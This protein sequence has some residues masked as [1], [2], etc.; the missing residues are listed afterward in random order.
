MNALLSQTLQFR[1]IRLR[2]VIY[3]SILFVRFNDWHFSQVGGGVCIPS[4]LC[5]DDECQNSISVPDTVWC[6]Y[7]QA[8]LWIA[9]T[10]GLSDGR[11]LLCHGALIGIRSSESWALSYT[12]SLTVFP[13]ACYES[14][15]SAWQWRLCDHSRKRQAESLPINTSQECHECQIQGCSSLFQ[16]IELICDHY[17][18]FYV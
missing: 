3:S 9:N 6:T 14:Y 2:A 10:P 7:W 18:N 15:N 8:A 11:L 12:V 17:L 13:A 4:S 1:W 16:M 5:V